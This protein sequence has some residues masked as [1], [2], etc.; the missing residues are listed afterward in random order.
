MN[1]Y[2]CA[3]NNS[4]YSFDVNNRNTIQFNS[5]YCFFKELLWQILADLVFSQFWLQMVYVIQVVV[6]SIDG[7][8]VQ[9]AALSLMSFFNG[10]H[11][12][13]TN[14]VYWN[15]VIDGDETN[16]SWSIQKIL[17]DATHQALNLKTKPSILMK[18][19][20]ICLSATLN[21]TNNSLAITS[22]AQAN[23]LC[24]KFLSDWF[25]NE[26][27]R[28]LWHNILKIICIVHFAQNIV[29]AICATKQH[30]LNPDFVFEI[31]AFYGQWNAGSCVSFLNNLFDLMV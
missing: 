21:W 28:L 24:S 26:F 19:W 13:K 25:S 18:N 3:V 7:W 9:F 1:S 16:H 20:P 27:K 31:N 15:G 8:M 5:I 17:L 30:L 11:K 14:T 6:S 29:N 4:F 10:R 23:I 12:Y 2:N 22:S